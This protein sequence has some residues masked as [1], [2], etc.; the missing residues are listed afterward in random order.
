MRAQTKSLKS[1][2]ADAQNLLKSLVASAKVK[3]RHKW[4]DIAD[5]I[6]DYGILEIN[7][8]SVTVP[9]P[10]GSLTFDVEGGWPE[11]LYEFVAPKSPP[12]D[13]AE[14]AKAVLRNI[15]HR[16]GCQEFDTALSLFCKKYGRHE[17]SWLPNLVE[18][19]GFVKVAQEMNQAVAAYR[20]ITPR[21]R[22]TPHWDGHDLFWMTDKWTFRN[23]KEHA[24]SKEILDFLERNLWKP[25]RVTSLRPSQVLNAA[26]YLNKKTRPYIIWKASDDGWI[27]PTF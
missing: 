2:A 20:Q 3:P 7:A 16:W 8:W 17:E 12:C 19:E 21:G 14:M 27:D 18:T 22:M 1:K 9:V 24:T 11:E 10:E 23:Q 6:W 13:K 26:K 5:A 15:L 25:C 4:Q